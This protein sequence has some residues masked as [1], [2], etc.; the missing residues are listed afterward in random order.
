M[1][2]Q[3]LLSRAPHASEGKLSRWFR[4]HLQSFVATPVSRRV[5][6]RQAGGR[7]NIVESLSQRDKKKVVPTHDLYPK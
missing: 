5:D 1:G 4:L 6:V 2:D 3:N 7:K